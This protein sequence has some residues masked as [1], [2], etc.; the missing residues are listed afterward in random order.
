[1]SIGEL[2][3]WLLIGLPAAGSVVVFVLGALL[4]LFTGGTK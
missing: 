4:S 2:L 1:M 3:F